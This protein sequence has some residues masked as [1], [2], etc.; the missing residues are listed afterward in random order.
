MENQKR[1]AT[2]RG[3]AALGGLMF[4]FLGLFIFFGSLYLPS[5][6]LMFQLPIMVCSLLFLLAPILTM[7]I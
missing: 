3:Q 6:L 2:A 7:F 1:L 5:N 4:F